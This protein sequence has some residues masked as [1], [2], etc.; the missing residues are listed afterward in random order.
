MTEEC[1]GAEETFPMGEARS[2]AVVDEPFFQHLRS[3]GLPNCLRTSI[4]NSLVILLD[5]DGDGIKPDDRSFA[6]LLKFVSAHRD[7]AAPGLTLDRRGI[8]V[9][10]WEIPGTFR[11][12]LAF[13]PAGSIEWTILERGPRSAPVR[14]AGT[15]SAES[16]Q[17]PPELQKSIWVS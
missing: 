2:P 11:W 1:W 12:S 10:V 6:A 7:W 16:I 15:A 17:L 14:S 9:A 4:E 13:V 3:Q 5:D 8:F